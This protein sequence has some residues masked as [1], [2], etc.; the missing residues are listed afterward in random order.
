MS[1]INNPVLM[2][3]NL[4]SSLLVLVT[5]NLFDIATTLRCLSMGLEEGN[6]FLSHSGDILATLLSL[7]FFKGLLFL[8]I[9]A[10][11]YFYGEENPSFIQNSIIVVSGIFL[12]AVINNSILLFSLVIR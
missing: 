3:S 7:F 8:Y 5:L 2:K 1:E 9:L 10:M 4:T 6:P 12:V 11:I